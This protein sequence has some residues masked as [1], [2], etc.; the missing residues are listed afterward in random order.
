LICFISKAY[1][2]ICITQRS[3]RLDVSVHFPK[4]ERALLSVN[5]VMACP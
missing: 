5:K 2:W 3:M 1:S 4:N